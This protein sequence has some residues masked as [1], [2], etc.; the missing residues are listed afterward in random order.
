MKFQI[1]T[2]THKPLPILLI[3][4]LNPTLI[5][6]R[7][8]FEEYINVDFVYLFPF[9]SMKY[10]LLFGLKIMFTCLLTAI[11]LKIVRNVRKMLER[12]AISGRF[13][14]RHK[15]RVLINQT[16]QQQTMRLQPNQEG[17]ATDR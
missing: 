6:A 2:H 11:E 14:M 4:Y 13:H 8:R 10:T 9:E 5:A 12:S 16:Q 1:D 17:A 15:F 3:L 7:R